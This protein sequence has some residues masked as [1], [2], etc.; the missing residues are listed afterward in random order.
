MTDFLMNGPYKYLAPKKG[1]KN[2]KLKRN[3]FSNIH[4]E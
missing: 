4:F 2:Y 3:M 1:G